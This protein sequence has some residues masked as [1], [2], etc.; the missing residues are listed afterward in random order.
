VVSAVEVDC[1]EAMVN[2]YRVLLNGAFG[3]YRELMTQMTLNPAMGRYLNM[4]NNRSQAITGDPPNENYARELLQL[5]TLGLTSLN[6]DG[7]PQPGTNGQPQPAYTEEDVKELARLLT[8]WTFGD[9]N[10]S[11]RPTDLAG[12][13]YRVPMEAVERFHDT[14][15]KSLLGVSVPAGQTARQDLDKALDIVFAQPS[16]APFVCRQLIQRLVTS[17]PSPAYLAEVVAIF[18][19][20]GTGVKGD[21]RA[22]LQAILAHP[23]ANLGSADRGKMMEPALFI[24]SQLR[25][26]N[27]TVADHPFMSD[28]AAE[29]GQRVFYPP[30]V[31][32]YYSPFFRVRGTP[33]AGPEFQIHTSVSALVRINFVGRL[34]SGGFGDDVRVDWTP[35][36]SRAPD[37]A[38]LVDYVNT[39]FLGGMMSDEHRAAIIEAVQAS[40]SGDAQER[41]RTALYLTLAA[42]Q[43]YVER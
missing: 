40:P 33:L 9:G 8:G 12:E 5:F 29:M 42:A 15:A 3:N 31:F 13:N 41:A 14:G 1:G 7:S 22:V 6:P 39:L 25:T 18:N 35:F 30:S 16:L 24:I 2:Y 32:S 36:R 21:L 34:I 27:A 4:V 26:L 10:A 17:N 11:T 28:L 23:E 43:Y 20:N 38:A 19:N 37:A